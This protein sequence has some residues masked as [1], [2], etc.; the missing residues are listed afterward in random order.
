[1]SNIVDS[2]KNLS[3]RIWFSR[4]AWAR[5]EARLLSDQGH[6]QRLMVVYSVYSLCFAIALLKYK[7]VSDDFQNIF[8]VVLAVMLMAL[9]L[10]LNTRNFRER[11][12]QFKSGYLKLMD[13]ESR[14]MQVTLQRTPQA[15]L[16][17]YN[18]LFASY[19]Q[20]LNDVEH[21]TAGDALSARQHAAA[22]RT[23]GKLSA[24]DHAHLLL[25]RSWRAVWLVAFYLGPVL[26]LAVCYFGIRNNLF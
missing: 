16:D 6:A 1:M 20:I 4:E 3:D 12:Q 10:N 14:I 8:S 7:V 5:A 26:V 18:D 11:A 13:I 9:S 2:A 21:H 22:D 15:M 19:K 24:L 17:D 23:D 25:L